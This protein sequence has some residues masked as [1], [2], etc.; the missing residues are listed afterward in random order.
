MSTPTQH[1]AQRLR[2]V[3]DRNY[4]PNRYTTQARVTSVSKDSTG[5]VTSVQCTIDGAASQTVQVPYGAAVDVNSVI[6]VT[7][8]GTASAPVYQYGTTYA[9]GVAAGAVMLVT[10]PDGQ[11]YVTPGGVQSAKA[12]L[13]RNGDFTL[14]HKSHSNQPHGWVLS[15]HAQLVDGIEGDE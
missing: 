11:P 12:N 7:N 3:L 9:G 14:A 10:G 2:Q 15:G 4:A 13:L 1:A 6:G 5:R 8:V